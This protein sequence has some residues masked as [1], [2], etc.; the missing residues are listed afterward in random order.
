MYVLCP[1]TLQVIFSAV[2]YMYLSDNITITV[3][4]WLVVVHN[5]PTVSPGHA[6]CTESH[7]EQ[8]MQ[9]ENHSLILP[10]GP[11]SPRAHAVQGHTRSKGPLSQENTKSRAHKARHKNDSTLMSRHPTPWR[12]SGHR[13][14]LWHYAGIWCTNQITGCI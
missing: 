13:S 5:Q 12:V 2:K 11:R 10:K 1:C 14:L 6:S 9:P 7:Q 3:S 4:E 8:I